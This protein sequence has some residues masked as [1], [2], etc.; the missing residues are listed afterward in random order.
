VKITKTQ[1]RETIRKQ[2]REAIGAQKA[3]GTPWQTVLKI[4]AQGNEGV[5]WTISEEWARAMIA[6][7]GLSLAQG[8]G[9]MSGEKSAL[10]KYK[11]TVLRLKRAFPSHWKVYKGP[12]K[13]DPRWTGD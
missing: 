9:D 12:W 11:G 2:I 13:P 1:L 6:T 8:P 3:P 5:G 7:L 10:F 4:A